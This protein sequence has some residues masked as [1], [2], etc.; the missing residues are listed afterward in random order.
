[1]KNQF[2][3]TVSNNK[4]DVWDGTSEIGGLS[5]DELLIKLKSAFGFDVRKMKD[6]LEKVIIAMYK[7]HPEDKEF[8]K[9]VTYIDN[10]IRYFQNTNIKFR[11]DKEKEIIIK[12]IKDNIK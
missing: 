7:R 11:S 8:L 9:E 3:V 4:F 12:D 2:V 1:M 6:N 10:M 5:S